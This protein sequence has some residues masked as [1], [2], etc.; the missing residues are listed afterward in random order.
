LV[1]C[2]N[3][4]NFT[5]LVQPKGVLVHGLKQDLH[6]HAFVLVLVVFKQ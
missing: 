2:E 3:G 4:H 5:H 1:I 6:V